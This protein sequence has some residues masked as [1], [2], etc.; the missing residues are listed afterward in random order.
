MKN[1]LTNE[2]AAGEQAG[3]V[4]YQVHEEDSTRIHATLYAPVLKE[5]C[6]EATRDDES[7]NW[8]IEVTDEGGYHTYDG[9]WRDSDRKSC[10]EVLAEAVSGSLLDEIGAPPEGAIS[11]AA[12][13]AAIAAREQEAWKPSALE[14]IPNCL[15]AS[16]KRAA[17][18]LR[19]NRHAGD[20]IDAS[21][22][23]YLRTTLASREE[24]PATPQANATG[25]NLSKKD[26]NKLLN[27][28]ARAC[29][30]GDDLLAR[31]AASKAIHEYLDAAFAALTQPT[32]VRQTLQALL[33]GIHAGR[34]IPLDAAS[35]GYC[36]ALVRAGE[37]ALEPGER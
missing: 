24:A 28:F 6:L 1:D 27:D 26:L 30:F 14:S 25:P 12:P 8:Y 4:A 2:P 17:S 18:L 35:A 36:A 33:D 9:Y 15:D 37:Q 19:S 31:M 34:F 23:E 7:R 11:L 20:A 10:A 16:L 13:G 21:R 32:T 5:F 29:A 22:L 3:A